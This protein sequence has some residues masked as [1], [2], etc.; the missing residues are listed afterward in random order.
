MSQRQEVKDI[1]ESENVKLNDISKI[2]FRYECTTAAFDD[3]F[4]IVMLTITGS[5]AVT[6]EHFY[7]LINDELTRE[8]EADFRRREEYQIQQLIPKVLL[9]IYEEWLNTNRQ[10]KINRV[11]CIDTNDTSEPTIRIQ[12]GEMDYT[13]TDTDIKNKKCRDML[14]AIK[15][16]KKDYP[17]NRI[18]NI[19]DERIDYLLLHVSDMRWHVF[20][21]LYFDE[22]Q[23]E[24]Y[25]YELTTALDEKKRIDL[26]KTYT[27]FRV[28]YVTKYLAKLQ[29][30][31]KGQV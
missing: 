15:S 10:I 30:S 5:I 24:R 19:S 4:G 11:I 1:L 27:P 8:E 12:K 20:E 17:N 28:Y 31:V 22:D 14:L 2:E 16:I 7:L 18:I 26:I 21:K 9:N 6:K 3:E 25:L 23:I 13:V 29:K